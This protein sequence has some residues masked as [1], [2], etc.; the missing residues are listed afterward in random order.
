MSLEQKIGRKLGITR[1]YMNWDRSIPSDLIR[2]SAAGGR[3]PY[4]AW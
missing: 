4:I 2:W 1:H 3:K